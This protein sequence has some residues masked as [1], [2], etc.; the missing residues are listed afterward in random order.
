[1]MPSLGASI[2]IAALSV[3]ISNSNA[4]FLTASPSF[5]CH[6]AILPVA[7]SISTF[8]NMTSTGMG[9]DPAFHEISDLLNNSGSLRHGGFF[10]GWIVGNGRVDAAEPE[11]RSIEVIEGFTFGNQRTDRSANAQSFHSLID[12]GKPRCL[13]D[14]FDDG[15]CIK[16]PQRAEINH[17]GLNAFARQN[18]RSLKRPMHHDGSGNNRD[19]AA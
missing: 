10:E 11:D 2:S 15:R 4:P 14:A 6:L 7:M 16:G 1:M 8:G 9:L 5:T 18:F 12:A 17:L 13:F 3:S 19:M